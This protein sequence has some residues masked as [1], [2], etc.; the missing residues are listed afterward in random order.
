MNCT[1][2][3]NELLEDI[4][5]YEQLIT[6][7]DKLPWLKPDQLLDI[8]E[9]FNAKIRRLE[10]LTCPR[11]M[12]LKEIIASR[13]GQLQGV[14]TKT[15]KIGYEYKN[16]FIPCAS[17]LDV[18]RNFLFQLWEDFPEKRESMAAAAKRLG[19]NRKYIACDRAG[20]FKG[21]DNCWVK[22]YSKK[23]TDGWYIDTNVVP[24]RIQKILPAVIGAAGMKWGLDARIICE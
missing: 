12:S 15:R 19:N 14:P 16:E 23:L 9:I 20:L 18:Y 17:Y 21:K 1:I 2:I 8:A 24:E 4:D 13:I 5:L 3:H 22:K 10:E 11:K 6:K 7:K